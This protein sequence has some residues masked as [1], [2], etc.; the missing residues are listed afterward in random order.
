VTDTLA[1]YGVVLRASIKVIRYRPPGGWVNKG[2][3]KEIEGCKE[4][5][6]KERK[7]N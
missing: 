2:K 6:K 4:I 7:I 3:K 1:Y 5:I